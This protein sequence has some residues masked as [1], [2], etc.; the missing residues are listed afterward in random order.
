M[1]LSRRD[2]LKISVF[3]GASVTL[4]LE[5]SVNAL[6]TSAA[7]IAESALPAPFTTPFEIPPVLA[8]V[9]SDAA[10]DYYRITMQSAVKEFIPGLKTEVWGYNG[11]VPGP[12]IRTRKG[13]PAMVRQINSLPLV[14]PTL[15]Y[16]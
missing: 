8:P 13:K 6:S 3:A 1:S 11:R 9:R 7:R 10:A 12:T 4:P 16:T 14:H 2:L 5:R 15:G